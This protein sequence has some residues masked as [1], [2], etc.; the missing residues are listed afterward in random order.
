MQSY[1]RFGYG[2]HGDL[3]TDEQYEQVIR[4]QEETDCGSAGI[5]FVS[6]TE[7]N[8]GKEWG[9]VIF[10]DLGEA[11]VDGKLITTADL[12][13]KQLKL[14]ETYQ[15]DREEI[16]DVLKRHGLDSN[17]IEHVQFI[18]FPKSY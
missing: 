13:A 16:V 6:F 5:E 17:L 4:H 2:F 11:G 10:R 18:I 12:I 7:D 14:N 3:L 8:E 9:T 1:N 15:K